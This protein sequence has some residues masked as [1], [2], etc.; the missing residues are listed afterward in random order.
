MR[1][2]V[3]RAF[4]IFQGRFEGSALP[5]MYTDVKGLVTTGTGNLID[6]IAAA[7]GLPW[8]N[9][10]GSAADQATIAAEWHRIKDAW[11]AVQSTGSKA[12]ATLHLEPADLDWLLT[13][14]AKSNEDLIRGEFADYDNWPSDAQLAIHSDAWAQ[15]A[16]FAG[17]PHLRAALNASPPDF[18]AA[19]GPPG[20]AGADPSKRGQAW[21]NDAGNPGLRPRNL[22]NKILWQNAARVQ[23]GGLDSETLYW[24]SELPEGATPPPGSGWGRT[25]GELALFVLLLGGAGMAILHF[26]PQGQ[27]WWA[28]SGKRWVKTHEPAWLPKEVRL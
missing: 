23:A 6:P 3:L 24:P 7:L 19:A 28:K 14:K 8:K 17:W 9:A 11:P 21:L 15:G 26:T 1:A 2:A 22:Q 13:S 20:D 12:I 27:A 5:Y 18:M 16:N 4:P 25:L 10:D